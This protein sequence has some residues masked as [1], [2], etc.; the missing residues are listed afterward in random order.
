MTS[1]NLSKR[2]DALDALRGFAVLTMV[3]SGTIAYK[4]LPPWMYH[5]QLPPPTHK[6]NGNLPGLTWVDLVFP[7]FLFAMGAAI[8]LALSGKIAR[9]WDLKKIIVSILIRFF[10]LGSFAII[11]QHLRPFTLNPTP[12]SQTWWMA[13]AGF[14]IIFFMYVRLPNSILPW[15]RKSL[16]LAAW[17]LG[18]IIIANW[19]YVKGIG[20]DLKR[21]DIILVVLANVAFFG[22]IIWL[23]TRSNLWLRLGF[24]GLLLAIGL[25]SNDDGWIKWL[26]NQSPVPWIFQFDYLKYLFIAIPGTIVGDL[27]CSWLEL[28]D[29]KD[30]SYGNW[31]ARNFY[32]IVLLSFAINLILLIG[33]QGRWVWQ[34]TLFTAVLGLSGLTLFKNPGNGAEKLLSQLYKWGI[35]WLFLGL[36]FEPYQ[37]GIKKDSATYSYF[38][39]TTG[40]AILLLIAFTIIIDVWQKRSW[41]ALLID[42]GM[43]PMIGY[44]GFANLIWPILRLNDWESKIIDFTSTPVMGF[45]RGVFYTLIVAAVASLLTKLKL[46]LRT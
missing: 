25:S 45:I 40:M 13:F 15:L 17:T 1:P 44:M 29:R 5:A 43:N 2:A 9:G 12:T 34:T 4:I 8:P 16:T 42:N 30:E 14:F 32:L 33:L 20:F 10:L 35:F 38:F 7:L 46:F 37:G 24:L 28:P 6:F 18:I 27:I 11:L 19:Q 36:L 3:L 26:W 21:S 41:M 23:F 39:V 31:Q 22:A